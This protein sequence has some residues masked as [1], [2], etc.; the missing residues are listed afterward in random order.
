MI[1]YKFGFSLR[2]LINVILGLFRTK[3]RKISNLTD[4]GFI[5]CMGNLRVNR[6]TIILNNP[7]GDV[8]KENLTVE[9]TSCHPTPCKNKGTCTA[10]LGLTYSCSCP[11]FFS[12]P[13]CKVQGI[14]QC[15]LNYFHFASLKFLLYK[16][17]YN[18]TTLLT[19][20]FILGLK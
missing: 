6:K 20:G 19:L 12:G 15:N 4:L 16:R 1:Y 17:S 3:F 2:V 7:G 13:I 18:L 5:G 11:K 14:C 10:K 9:C 8:V